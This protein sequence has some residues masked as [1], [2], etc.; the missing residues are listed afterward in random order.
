MTCCSSP[1]V[2]P[3]TRAP[4]RR[5]I[6]LDAVR[7][8]ASLIV[9]FSHCYLTIPEEPRSRFEAGLLWPKL[10]F[11]L[12]NGDGAVMI[13]FC[14][15]RICPRIAVFPWNTAN[16][17][18]LCPENVFAVS[19]ACFCGIDL[20]RRL[21]LWPYQPAGSPRRKRLVQYPLA[22]V[23]A[24]RFRSCRTFP[25]DRNRAG[26]ELRYCDVVTRLRNAHFVTLPASDVSY[27]GTCAAPS[28]RHC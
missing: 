11:L 12:H 2:D 10:L 28:L 6:S 7:G 5:L 4:P 14:S 24:G 19:Q 15:E 22:S 26:H 9:V 13:F 3:E 16:L 1:R 23:V 27:A 25:D 21:S 8:I 17:R 20:H 18:A